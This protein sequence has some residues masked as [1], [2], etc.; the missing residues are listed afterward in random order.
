MGMKPDTP[1][2]SEWRD[3]CDVAERRLLGMYSRWFDGLAPE[4]RKEIHE[5]AE[6]LFQ[7]LFRAGLRK[8]RTED[9][10]TRT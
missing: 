4:V 1:R 8:F 5:I 10:R 3:A 2:P 9:R 6:P 7:L